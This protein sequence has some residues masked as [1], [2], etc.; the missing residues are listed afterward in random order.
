MP[1]A[2]AVRYARALVDLVLEPGAEVRPQAILQELDAFQDLLAASPALRNVLLSPAVRAAQKRALVSELVRRLGWSDLLRRF[3]L[4]VIDRRR[5]NLLGEI[6]EAVETTLDERL[7]VVRADVTSARELEPA[8]RDAVA[9]ALA[10]LTGR[11]PRPRFRVDP[12]LIG[13]LVVRVGSTIYDG[14][15]RGRLEGLRKRLAGVEI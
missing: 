8:Q 15:V 13:G 10:R 11:Q 3:L 2:V 12:E 4:V 1:S 5:V 6:R 14:S 9:Q 7:G